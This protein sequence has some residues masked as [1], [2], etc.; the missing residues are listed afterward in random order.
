MRC[1]RLWKLVEETHI[2]WH[3]HNA[4]QLGASLAYYSA[5][6]LAPFVVLLFAIFTL[7]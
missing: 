6:S 4:A 1:D 5:L 7:A 2:Q 3:R